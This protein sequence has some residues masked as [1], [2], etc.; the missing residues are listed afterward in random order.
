MATGFVDE[1]DT[2]VHPSG[3]DYSLTGR[4]T[5]AEFVDKSAVDAQNVLIWVKDITLV[6]IVAE[7]V[8]N[9]RLSRTRIDNRGAP[10]AHLLMQTNV[11]ESK[12]NALQRYSEYCN[13]LIWSLPDGSI[14]V[15]KPNMSQTAAGALIL[16]STD[17]SQNNLL[18]ARVRRNVN[19]AI[20]QIAV[21]LT[22]M[23]SVAAG[24]I[25][26]QNRDPDMRA[27]AASLAGRSV[28]ELY[29]LGNGMDAANQLTVVGQGGGLGSIGNAYA[30]RKIA[31]ENMKILDV[32]AC[33]EGHVNEAGL[34]YNTDQVY[35]V[36]IEDE[37]VAEPMYVYSCSYELT[38]EH[39]KMTRMRLCRLGTIVADVPQYAS[40][41]TAG[42]AQ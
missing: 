7:L 38:L 33:V 16:N 17:P 24:N 23:Q 35:A 27:V 5:L 42:P 19:Q 40:V 4:D 8:K 25:T 21:Q 31:Q 15:G 22:N 28:Y 14:A 1:T 20:R 39:G 13:S 36:I 12:M 32:E 29:S 30:L 11:G 9:T 37:D 2:H 41:E 26:L 34:P 6:K 18:D 3:V 10:S